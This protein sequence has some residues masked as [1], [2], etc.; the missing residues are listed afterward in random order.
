MP[1]TVNL[2]GSTSSMKRFGYTS[3]EES[4]ATLSASTSSSSSS[5]PNRPRTVREAVNA[6]PCKSI[7][8]EGSRHFQGPLTMRQACNSP[9]LIEKK[10]QVK[11][12]RGPLTMRQAAA[13]L[14]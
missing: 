11:K 4:S 5:L 12:Y 1:L 7:F 2:F 8:D 10:K 14:H 3:S 9:P 6:K 13:Y